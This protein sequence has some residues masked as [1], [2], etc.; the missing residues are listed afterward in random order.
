[1]RAHYLQH[2]D[3]ERLGSIRP[4][5]ESQGYDV[6]ATRLY[7]G[8]ALP[9][10]SGLDLLVVM[11]GMMSVNDEQE[12]PWLVAEKA[13]IRE[14]IDQGV[15][16]L[17]VCLGAQLIANVLGSQVYPNRQR[18]IGWFP[19]EGQVPA[20]SDTFVFPAQVKV[21]HW[22]GETFDLP[23]GAVALASSAACANQAFQWGDRVIGLQCHLESTPELVRAFVEASLDELQAE[24][25]VQTPEQLLAIPAEELAATTVLMGRVL[26]YLHGKRTGV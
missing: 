4:W 19:I 6:T 15:A 25:W 22:H 13:F 18:E 8:E 2:A 26:E 12:F 14:A 10:V 17:G 1:M 7:C 16:V 3:F 24:E 20:Q 9:E 21:L 23:E 5:L 11:G